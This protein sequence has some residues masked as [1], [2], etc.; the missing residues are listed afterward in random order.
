[1]DNLVP[2]SDHDMNCGSFGDQK[3]FHNLKTVP[4]PY[5]NALFTTQDTYSRCL[6]MG[7][8]WIDPNI[9]VT[10]F[11]VFNTLINNTNS[12]QCSTVLLFGITRLRISR[13]RNGS[14]TVYIYIL[15]VIPCLLSGKVLKIKTHPNTTGMHQ[16]SKVSMHDNLSFIMNT[17][18]W[19]RIL[20]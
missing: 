1:M 10:I 3:H 16:D 2:F 12:R 15:I 19:S 6:N 8:F 4:Y 17:C 5:S 11:L 14:R 9:H 20:E 13:E 18:V 7:T